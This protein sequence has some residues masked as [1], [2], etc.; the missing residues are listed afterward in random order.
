[1]ESNIDEKLNINKIAPWLVL[2]LLVVAV[3]FGFKYFTKPQET[4]SSSAVYSVPNI[5]FN[6]LTS[7]QLEE[8]EPF[9]VYPSFQE[10]DASSIISGRANPFA[11]LSR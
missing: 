6:F 10:D 7:P 5:D 2:L 1:M 8:L 4:G 9:P 11:P 3:F